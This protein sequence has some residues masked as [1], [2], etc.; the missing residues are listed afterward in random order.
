MTL[1]AIDTW[2]NVSMGDVA[3]TAFLKAVKEDYFK[4]GDDFFRNIECDE[5]LDLM[6]ELGVERS[7]VTVSA[8]DPSERV[9]EFARKH[10]GRFFVAAVVDP[11][12]GMRGVWELEALAERSPVAMARFAPFQIGIAPN[13]PIYYPTYVKCIEM[14]LPMGI[15]TGICGP[16]MPSECQHPMHLDVVCHYFPELKLIMQHG[17]DPWWETAIRLMIKYKNLY[18]MTSAYAPKYLP[19]SLL[20]YMRTRGRQKILFAS[21]HPVLAMGRCLDEAQTLDLEE[22]ILSDYLYGNAD[23]VL[24]SARAPRYRTYAIDEHLS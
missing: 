19:E 7:L 17:A 10:P 13:D 22:A 16:P 23:R 8:E 2:V 18:L 15:N 21:D 6:D 20:H 12:R 14:D 9:L 4:A 3:D 1:R 5:L 24:F 11:T